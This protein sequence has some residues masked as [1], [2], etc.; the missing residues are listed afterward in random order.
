[1]QVHSSR[2]TTPPKAF[3]EG[4]KQP[5]QQHAKHSNV[6][7]FLSHRLAVSSSST[8]HA[9]RVTGT[10]ADLPPT[11]VCLSSHWARSASISSTI[12]YSVQQQPLASLVAAE[13]DA[14]LPSKELLKARFARHNST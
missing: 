11:F 9:T 13:C 12:R 7:Y 10:A 3:R 6:E 4:K 8:N 14:E 2:A 1:M 5:K